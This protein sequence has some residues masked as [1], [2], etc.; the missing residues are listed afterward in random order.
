MYAAILFD[1]DGLLIDSEAIF[2]AVEIELLREAG[3]EEA[4]ARAVLD[5]LIGTD[6]PTGRVIMAERLPDVDLSALD[7]TRFERI[8]AAMAAGIP[9]RPRVLELLDA[10]DALGVPRAVATNSSHTRAEHKLTIT[11]LRDRV[12]AV[13]GQ[14]MVARPKPAPDVYIA[15]AQALGVPVA[16]CLAF[17]DSDTGARS[18]H[19]AGCTVVQVPNLV[20]TDGVF[21]H[22]VSETVWHGAHA[23]GLSL[24][25]YEK[26]R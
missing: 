13:V 14:D 6:E 25:D 12:H 9:L 1:L 7:A 4:R 2:H 26:T 18:A 5:A 8:S 3:V 16:D 21:A 24:P 17:E 20:T 11:G 22:H 23:A 19:A 10:L 15:A